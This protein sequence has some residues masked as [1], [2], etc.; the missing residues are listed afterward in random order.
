MFASQN[1][2]AEVVDTLLQHGARVDLQSN[3]SAALS[4]RMRSEG[5]SIRSV[6]L[7]VCV[8]TTIFGLQATRRLM[9]YTNSF[10]ATRARKTMWRFC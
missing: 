8:S 5:Y 6:C 4:A 1:G 10:S 3:V 7:C 9:S 2:H